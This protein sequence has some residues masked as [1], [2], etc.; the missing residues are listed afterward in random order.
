M[1]EA[2]EREQPLL[3]LAGSFGFDRSDYLN[4]V[5]LKGSLAL[6]FSFLAFMKEFMNRY[7]YVKTANAVNPT[8]R[9]DTTQAKTLSTIRDA[10]HF[11]YPK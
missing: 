7:P 8:I 10:I 1:A 11:Q 5:L 3:E 6:G 9:I 2:E 4:Q